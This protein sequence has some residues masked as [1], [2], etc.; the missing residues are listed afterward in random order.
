MAPSGLVNPEIN[1]LHLAGLRLTSLSPFVRG[2][3]SVA[4]IFRYCAA[5]SFLIAAINK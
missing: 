4:M 5:H 2:D 1:G 3:L